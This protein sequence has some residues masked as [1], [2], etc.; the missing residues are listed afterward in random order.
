MG[1]ASLAWGA[2]SLPLT[3][4]EKE[5]AQLEDVSGQSSGI[6][7]PGQA[8]VPYP[9]HLPTQEGPH[10]DTRYSMKDAACCMKVAD[11]SLLGN[12]YSDHIITCCETFIQKEPFRTAFLFFIFLP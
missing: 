3:P 10:E 1:L 2:P 8:T 6:N 9:V 4:C 7:W 11:V 5:E 12:R